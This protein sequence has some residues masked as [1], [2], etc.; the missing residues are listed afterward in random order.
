MFST[1]CKHCPADNS[2]PPDDRKQVKAR[3]KT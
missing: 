1:S 3:V 2:S